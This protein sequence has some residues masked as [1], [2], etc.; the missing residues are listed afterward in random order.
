MNKRHFPLLLLL[1]AVAACSEVP[2]PRPAFEGTYRLQEFQFT[3]ATLVNDT[4]ADDTILSNTAGPRILV[5]ATGGLPNKMEIDFEELV[6]D[7]VVQA[8]PQHVGDVRVESKYPIMITLTSNAFILDESRFNTV[9]IDGETTV[10]IRSRITMD[11]RFEQNELRFDFEA[12]LGNNS[13]IFTGTF[14]GLRQP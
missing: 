4:I 1:L 13:V 11:G 12:V 2:D 5:K 9:A 14:T 7:L 3:Y 8:S 10:I 6:E